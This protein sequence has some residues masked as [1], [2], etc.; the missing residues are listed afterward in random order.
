[1]L[2]KSAK[3]SITLKCCNLALYILKVHKGYSIN[4]RKKFIAYCV[5]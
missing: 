5:L 3:Y 2:T 4:H 1:M